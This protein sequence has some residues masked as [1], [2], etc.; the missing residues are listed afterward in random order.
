MLYARKGKGRWH[1]IHQVGDKGKVLCGRYPQ[2]GQFDQWTDKL[3]GD[4][5]PR[6]EACQNVLTARVHREMDQLAA[7]LLAKS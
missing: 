5:H 7:H 1:T 3:P 4:G 6:C 2:D